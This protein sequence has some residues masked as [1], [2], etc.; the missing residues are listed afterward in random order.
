MRSFPA[1]RRACASSIASRRELRAHR[2]CSS[3]CRVRIGPSCGPWATRSFLGSS[4]SV[5]TSSRRRRMELERVAPSSLRAPGCSS[6][7]TSFSGSTRT[8]SPAGT[9]RWR[10]SP[11]S[12]STTP[13]LPSPSMRSRS[14][15]ARRNV[16]RV[17]ATRPMATTSARTEP[18]SSSSRVRPS[19]AATSDARDRRWR[20]SK[21]RCPRSGHARSSRRY[22]W[23]TPGTCRPATRST[24]AS[25][26]ICWAWAREASRSC[27]AWCSS[28]SCA[29]ARSS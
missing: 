9:T 5:R 28:T 23:A 21:P 16:S 18:P 3:S 15:S 10:K 26:A 17:A 25:E 20:G 14:G 24:K 2:P 8:Y 27:S 4:R 19:P 6:I 12:C 22:A 11:A 29:F 7:P 1:L 13:A